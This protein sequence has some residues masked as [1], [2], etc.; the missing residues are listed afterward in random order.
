[1]PESE[2]CTNSG[3]FVST[4][5]AHHER[6]VLQHPEHAVQ[7]LQAGERSAEWLYG[8]RHVLMHHMGFLSCK[9]TIMFRSLLS[10]IAPCLEHAGC[11][12]HS[13]KL[14][15]QKRQGG[16]ALPSDQAC[17]SL[18][19][20]IQACSSA[21]ER[22]YKRV[23]QLPQLLNCSPLRPVLPPEGMIFTSMG[24]GMHAKHAIC[25]PTR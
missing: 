17:A 2:Q 8:L 16:S 10:E 13:R 7:M 1:M 22:Q 18:K 3:C 11:N 19:C 15:R 9:A 21:I 6:R 14:F 25:H 24:K 20:P 4:S 5:K 23:Y 12:A